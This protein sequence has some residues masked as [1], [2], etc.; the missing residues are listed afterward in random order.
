EVGQLIGEITQATVQQTSGIEQVNA[1]VTQLDQM[2]QQNAALV[3]QSSAAAASLKNQAQRLQEL[4]AAFR[5]DTG[6]TLPQP[7]RQ[8]LAAPSR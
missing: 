3:E 6:P 8:A 1:A 5:I 4:V 7:T 2:T